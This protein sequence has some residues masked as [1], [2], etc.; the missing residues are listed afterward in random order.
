MVQPLMI[1]VPY[2]ML[3]SVVTIK[4]SVLIARRRPGIELT[5][6][7]AYILPFA[8]AIYY[9]AHYGLI[10]VA[11]AFTGLYLVTFPIIQTITNRQVQLTNRDFFTALWPAF[12]S[13]MVMLAAGL[14]YKYVLSLLGPV[15]VVV[16]LALGVP[17]VGSCYLLAMWFLFRRQTDELVKLWSLL[18]K[19]KRQSGHTMEA[20]A[21]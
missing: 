15:P 4:G 17:L 7:V 10:G 13:S 11:C 9:G 14:L 21:I 8:V 5:W 6:N 18:K 20:D 12:A 19:T 16:T 1:L 3:K 2:A